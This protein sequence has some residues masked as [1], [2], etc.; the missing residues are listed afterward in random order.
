MIELICQCHSHWCVSGQTCLFP[1]CKAVPHHRRGQKHLESRE[2]YKSWLGNWSSIV[3]AGSL[4]VLKDQAME[5]LLG[6]RASF[7]EEEEGFPWRKTPLKLNGTSAFHRTSY[8]TLRVLPSIVKE[9]HEY[10]CCNMNCPFGHPSLTAHTLG[11][12]ERK[13]WKACS[14]HRDVS[15]GISVCLSQSIPASCPAPL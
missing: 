2:L 6:L 15:C 5:L 3:S 12:A 1:F 9:C 10:Q 11:Q 14:F 8:L 4:W 13:S 7:M